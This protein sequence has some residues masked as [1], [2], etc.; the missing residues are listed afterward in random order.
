MPIRLNLLAEAQAAE[1]AR[2]RD[3]V[4]RAVWLAALIIVLILVWSSSLQLK[5]IYVGSELSRVQAQV[6]ARTNEYHGIL[7]NQNKI[8]DTKHRLQQLRL[9]SQDRFLNGTLLDALQRST[10]P[11]VELLRLRVDQLYVVFEGTKSK[12][13][14]DGVLIPG[15]RPTNTEKIV[16]TLEGAD[17]SPNPGDQLNKYKDALA[18]NPYFKQMLIKTNGINLK[19]LTPPQT[20]PLTGK[21]S[22]IFTLECRYPEITR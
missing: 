7:D 17:S 12:T 4:K 11:H 5:A 19:N 16:L 10:V 18:S 21:R 15:K 9:L 13:N 22:A 20:S 2:R 3:P 14:D 1:E 6:N 8:A